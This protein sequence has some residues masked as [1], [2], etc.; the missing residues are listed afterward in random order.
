MHTP[1]FTTSSFIRFT[2]CTFY[3]LFPTWICIRRA[4]TREC[5]VLG[6]GDKGEIHVLFSTVVV[7]VWIFLFFARFCEYIVCYLYT[8]SN[9]ARIIHSTCKCLF[10]DVTFISVS[11]VV[12]E[13]FNKN[14]RVLCN[15]CISLYQLISCMCSLVLYMS[16]THFHEHMSLISC[17]PH[18]YVSVERTHMNAACLVRE[19][20]VKYTCCSQ[21]V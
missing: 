9:N 20:K 5:S 3:I 7:I 12:E 4:Y 1:P 15:L 13:V 10:T 16:T 17:S 18:E 8:V 11:H 19:I 2:S 21:L 14:T 6:S